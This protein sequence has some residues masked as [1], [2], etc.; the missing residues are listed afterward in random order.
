MDISVRHKIW[1]MLKR[2]R[3]DRVILL[4]THF[5]EE[6]DILADRIGIIAQGKMSCIGSSIFLKNRFGSGYS[7]IIVKEQD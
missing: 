7:L 4:T 5:M 1:E 3:K 6:A 2:Y